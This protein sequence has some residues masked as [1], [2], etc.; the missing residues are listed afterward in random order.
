MKIQKFSTFIFIACTSLINFTGCQAP[1]QPE[2]K[3]AICVLHPTAGNNANGTVSFTKSD[4]G[5]VIVVNMAG[6]SPGKHGF[7]VHEYGDCSRP[8]GTSAG[9]H[10][11]PENEKHG[12]PTD[13]HRHVG[14][15]GNIEAESTGRVRE[16]WVDP[17]IKLNGPHSII[18]RAIVVHEGEDDLTTQPTGAAGSRIACGVIG[19]AE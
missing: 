19:I 7:H 18:G 4:S 2:I 15:L 8:D 9:G 11:N 6:L 1:S 14:D 16:R 3:N 12:G 5:V 13:L 10:F 17:V